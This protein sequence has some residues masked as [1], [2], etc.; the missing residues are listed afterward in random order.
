V[1]SFYNDND[2]KVCSWLRELVK[3]GLVSDGT[4]DERSIAEIQASDLAG[5]DR[6]HLFAGIGGWDYALQLAG[7]PADRPVWTG[8]CPC[9]P[10]SAAGKRKAQG[11]S[12]HLWPEMFRLIR[13]CRPDTVFGEQ[14]PGAIGLG[15]LDGIC[16]DL[17][18]EGYAVGA[19]VLGAHSVGAPHI[20]QRLYWVANSKDTQRRGTGEK[21]DGRWRSEKVG[22]PSPDDGLSNPGGQG[23]QGWQKQSARPEREATQRS[24][25]ADGMAFSDG[26]DSCPERQQRGREQR[27]QQEDGGTGGLGDPQGRGCRIS[28]DAARQ[29]DG[30]Y[31]VG[32]EWAGSQTILCRDGKYHRIP[33]E[34]AFQPLVDGLS[35]GRVGLLRGAGNA[36]VPQVAATFVRAFLDVETRP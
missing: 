29:R 36:I 14:V 30:G 5:C 16:A 4:I 20:R 34:P 17:E 13:E 1:T 31:V 23:L 32:S 26:R 6:V 22:R 27:Q 21:D 11:D 25:D 8:S 33:T 35:P 10:F 3:A 7:W 2:A 18:A 24:G 19:C 9:Q 12:R 15:W 28:G